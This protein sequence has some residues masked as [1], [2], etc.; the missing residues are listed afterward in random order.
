SALNLG[1]GRFGAA[2]PLGMI[3]AT[4]VLS[5]ANGV[6]VADFN[7]DG[8]SDLAVVRSE[9][10]R[11]W[12]S[13]GLGEFARAVEMAS[14]PTLVDAELPQLQ[15][16]D[17][18]GDGLTDLAL[19]GVA[20][21]RYWLN[22]AA[23]GFGEQQLISQTP[24][25]GVNTEVR[26]A[27]MNGNGTADLVWID[28]TAPVPWQYLELFPNGTP[29]LITQADNGMGKILR[30]AYG[31]MGQ[32]RLTAEAA[33]LG[34]KHRCPIGQMLT[35]AL[36]QDDNLGN[37]VRT[38]YVYGDGYFDAA[39][40]EFRGFGTALSLSLGDEAQP[41]LITQHAYDVGIEEEARKGLTLSTERRDEAGG[42]FDTA[43]TQYEVRSVAEAADGTALRYAAR[44]ATERRVFELGAEAKLIRTTFQEDDF[45]NVVLE[46]AQ[47]EVLAGQPEHGDDE[48][49]TRR[50]YAKNESAWI[51]DR[52]S[53]E[54]IDSF[55]GTMLSETRTYYDGATFEG[56]GLGEVERGNPTRVTSYID[57]EKGFVFESGREFDQYGNSIA[58]LDARGLRTEADYHPENHTYLI[59]ERQFP[60][61]GVVLR[62]KAAFDMGF[63]VVRR[64]EGPNGE[65]TE[66]VH[67]ALSRVVKIIEPGDSLELPTQE[68]EY[69]LSAPIST[70]REERR[71]R[72]GEGDTVSKI[73]YY[74]GQS[75]LRA[76][77]EEGA[78]PG[79]W[80][81][82]QLESFGPRGSKAFEIYPTFVSSLEF[83]GTAPSEL[84][85]KTYRYDA[86]QRLVSHVEPD[87]ATIATEYAPL[88]KRVWDEHDTDMASTHYDT[89]MLFESD[90]LE[91]LRRVTES[92]AGRSVVSGEYSYDARDLVTSIIDA[93]QQARRY[94]YDG[95]KRRIALEDPNAGSWQFIYADSND[96]L[97]QVDP[98]GGQVSY[99]YDQ[100]GR[101]LGEW[102]QLPG[103][104]KQRVKTYH[105]DKPS[106]WYPN[107]PNLAGQLAWVEDEAGQLFFGYTQR[108]LQSREI[109]R[110]SD[111][112]VHDGS[113]SF[114]AMDR[115]SRRQFP[116][117]S[118]YSRTYDSR[119]LVKQMGPF[120]DGI[121]W[122]AQG[123]LTRATFGNGVEETR[124]YDARYRLTGLDAKQGSATVR[125][126]EIG[127]TLG[128][129]VERITDR[130][131]NASAELKLDGQFEYDDRYRLLKATDNTG[132]TRW[133]YDDMANVLNVSSTHAGEHLNVANTY[134]DAAG[135]ERRTTFGNESWKFDASGR[136]ISDGTRELKWDA[137]GRL[138]RVV[139]AETVETYTYAHND[140]R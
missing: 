95:R 35:V 37:L 79:A 74:D 125:S 56:L 110:W 87:G 122:D 133:Q 129:L 7:G 75:R 111:G 113:T 84:S 78:E 86:L 89:P 127:Y 46:S 96:L 2:K 131:P 91:R 20:E 103:E 58:M 138:T 41:S 26:V 19:V 136:L 27:D 62:W 80:V 4:E 98:T 71:E 115:V 47:G 15:V 48:R 92:D 100:S 140:A 49:I 104:K 18:N 28:P 137:K 117:G 44:V 139:K 123:L 112:T 36:E 121:N 42:V 61:E 126:I 45:G 22:L 124:S 67:D 118:Y 12:P 53:S 64:I 66:F 57:E 108:S 9:S 17:L 128:S 30:V 8:L 88:S 34:W 38:E 134:A 54:R 52:V 105:Y 39:M 63:G 25:R 83:P 99:T 85:G 65:V 116:D 29:G 82:T 73:G 106:K 23:R 70:L 68:F 97:E 55:A 3:S 132:E 31:G 114:D 107:L 77:I 10:A 43:I 60:S 102:H 24:T 120:I 14:A 130:N 1:E 59:E 16:R 32:A 5:F 6:R 33:G 72:S 93:N 69:I 51:L 90:G 101:V 50:T 119:G 135:P 40:R 13:L 81:L 94:T 21:V 76:S 11:Y 109:R